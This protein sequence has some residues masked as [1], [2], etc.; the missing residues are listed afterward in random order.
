MTSSED[1][2]PASGQT[3]ALD[4]SG[5]AEMLASLLG[6]GAAKGGAAAA[7]LQ[8]LLRQLG[9]GQQA[10]TEGLTPELLRSLEKTPAAGATA[11]PI[12]DALKRAAEALGLP[13]ALVEKLLP[14]ILG[15]L[16]GL[17][18]AAPQ[19]PAGDAIHKRPAA[20][21][22]T[23]AKPASKP[24]ESAARKPKTTEA[25]AKKPKATESTARK[26][27]A[28]ESTARKPKTTEASKKPKA[29]STRKPSGSGSKPRSGSSGSTS[30]RK[31]KSEPDVSGLEDIIKAL[32][33]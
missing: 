15:Q 29:S 26:P 24:A 9:G 21:A 8:A 12:P 2:R 6:G 19:P 13:P 1:S 28:S 20:T 3:G 33:K 18:Q 32:I 31:R 30:R 25:T 7:P 22:E 23:P 10:E 5:L 4:A 16:P 11:S 17:G 27:K 14:G